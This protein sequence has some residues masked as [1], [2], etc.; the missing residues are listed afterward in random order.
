MDI[1]LAILILLVAATLLAV[2]KQGSWALVV[3][4]LHRSR[5]I[6]FS[7]WWKVLLGIILAG[8][9]QILIPKE[10]IANWMGPASGVIGVLTGSLA[11]MILT[12]GAFVV[13][14]IIGSIYAAGAGAGPIIAL[15]TAANLTR[16]Q[17]LITIEIPIF[18][19][20]IS[21][22]RYL[23][24]LFVPPVIGFLGSAVFRLF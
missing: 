11:G 12:G 21:M 7:M 18:G 14:P 10:T 23:I 24:C 6:L 19:I 20:R 1:S 4:G 16:I 22:T 8:F 17:G 13:I 15:L 9:V 5:V 3:E 2:F